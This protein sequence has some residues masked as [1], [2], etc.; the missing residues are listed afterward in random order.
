[1]VAEAVEQSAYSFS[2]TGLHGR[3]LRCELQCARRALGGAASLESSHDDDI[4]Y[5]LFLQHV[6]P[7][8]RTEQQPSHLCVL[9]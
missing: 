7:L 1:M 9:K 4:L 8:A 2:M 5:A 6:A 3:E